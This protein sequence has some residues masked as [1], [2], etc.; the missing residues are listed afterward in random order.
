VKS[1]PQVWMLP[2]GARPVLEFETSASR[3]EIVPLQAGEK[4]RIEAKRPGAALEVT[5]VGEKVCVRYAM[6]QREARPWSGNPGFSHA[7]HRTHHAENGNPFGGNPFEGRGFEEVVRGVAAAVLG[8]R[9]GGGAFTLHLPSNVRAHISANMG[10]V[11]ATGLSGCDLS[12]QT[13]AGS[14]MLADCRGRFTLKA[15]AGRILGRR[16]G[17]TF[18][19]ESGM[20]EATLDIVALDPGAHRVVSTMGAVKVD[21]IP[22]L[23]VRIESRTV[24]GSTRTRY[25]SNNAAPTLLK[26]EAELG[27]VRVREGGEYKDPRRGDWKDWRTEWRDG[28]SPSA[29]AKPDA[30]A[31]LRRILD[32]VAQKKVSPEEAERLISAINGN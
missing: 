6:D 27:S 11:E 31:E 29:P 24:M 4:P 20:G 32:L 3:L 22:G 18:D 13:S 16:V 10:E 14:L 28:P 30:D 12:V 26:L 7:D 23:D 25:P 1:A 2:F 19:V 15:K 9:G 8:P 17:G 21:L 5:V